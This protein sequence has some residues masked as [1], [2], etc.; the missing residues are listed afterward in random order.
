[1]SVPTSAPLL[2][3]L[4]GILGREALLLPGDAGMQRHLADFL[5]G[6][7]ASDVPVAVA[8]PASTA[9]VSAVMRCCDRHDQP[10]V[11]QGG[12]TGLVA[13]GRPEHDEVVVS[14]DRMRAI[15][16]TDTAAATMTLQAGVPLQAAQD[17]ALATGMM[18]PLDMGSRG[19]CTVGGNIATNA[20]GNRVLRYGMA[21]E[22]ILGIEAVLSN[23]TICGTLNKMQKNN[24]GYDVKQLFIGSEGTLGIV[25]RAVFRLYPAPTSACAALCTVPDYAAAVALLKLARAALGPALSAFELM[26]PEYYRFATLEAGRRGPL[27][28]EGGLV[29]LLD[30]LGT[31]PAVD[32]QRFETLLAGALADGV[33][34]DSVIAKSGREFEQFW[35]IREAIGDMTQVWGSFLAFDVS[36]PVCDIGAFVDDC[37]LR[38]RNRLPQVR[39]LAF[40]HIADS[41]VHF[42]CLAPELPAVAASL[43]NIIYAAVRDW[44]GSVSAEHG[45]GLDKK[46]YLSYSRS[47]AELKLMRELKA[48]LDPKALLNRGRVL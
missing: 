11:V 38:L 48:L 26:W 13:G 35:A 46:N 9:E 14:L 1:V 16:E 39:A 34:A 29:V 8:R 10:V 31:G 18:F 12:L 7:A 33:V 24:A 44:H 27:A 36:I 37:R 23:G 4:T 17:A 21:R 42:A 20:G 40:G 5:G 25:T 30:L 2:A 3:E 45:I 6:S 15:E 41:N 22:N 19:S 32:S 43:T 47:G 28:L